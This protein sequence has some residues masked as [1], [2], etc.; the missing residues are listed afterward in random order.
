MSEK[1]SKPTTVQTRVSRMINLYSDDRAINLGFDLGKV[2]MSKEQE[3]IVLKLFSQNPTAV[4]TTDKHLHE[5]ERRKEGPA[6]QYLTSAEF[7]SI[8]QL[9]VRLGTKGELVETA[10]DFCLHCVKL[11]G[12]RNW[13]G[14]IM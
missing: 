1:E 8:R 4:V 12:I 10:C 3:T 9:G 14:G 11:E 5:E 2:Q 13:S 7:E 6:S